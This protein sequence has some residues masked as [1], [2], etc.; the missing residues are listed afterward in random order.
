MGC[1]IQRE[2]PHLFMLDKNAALV[3]EFAVEDLTS[4]LDPTPAVEYLPWAE[5]S[6]EFIYI[7][8]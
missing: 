7:C 4:A 2:A 5:H 1:G 8:V 6:D 3:P